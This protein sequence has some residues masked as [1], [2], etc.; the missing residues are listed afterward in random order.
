MSGR[1]EAP[2]GSP[3]APAGEIRLTSE[4]NFS[5]SPGVFATWGAVTREG[6]PTPKGKPEGTT[7]PSLVL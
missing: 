4:A 7:A 3:V 1:P 2:P 6:L 5:H